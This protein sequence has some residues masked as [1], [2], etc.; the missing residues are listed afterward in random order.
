MDMDD[1][2]VWVLVGIG[3]LLVVMLSVCVIVYVDYH[4]TGRRDTVVKELIQP[5]SGQRILVDHCGV[6]H[7]LYFDAGQDEPT[8]MSATLG[9]SERERGFTLSTPSKLVGALAADGDVEA[10]PHASARKEAPPSG[11]SA[12][13]DTP[14]SRSAR[15]ALPSVRREASLSEHSGLGE[16]DA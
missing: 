13:N 2:L 5:D 6:K 12:R 9:A 10:S 1:D 11:R 3:G 8:R 14:P 16:S 7:G 4:C 15:N